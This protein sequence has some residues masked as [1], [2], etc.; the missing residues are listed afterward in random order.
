MKQYRGSK[1]I[2]AAPMTRA[3]YNAYRGWELPADE[4]GADEGYLV[5]YID[6]PNSN[7]EGHKGYISWSPKDVFERAYRLN[8]SLNFGDA[9]AAMKDGKRV[10][11]AGWNGEGMWIALSGTELRPS[12][13]E[14]KNLWSPHSQAEAEAQGGSVEV[15]PAIIMRT[16][17]GKIA[18]GWLASQ[19]DMLAEDW[20]ILD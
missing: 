18:M 7:H 19:A 9:I 4:D 1:T 16:A 5:E 17:D 14:T 15:L 20:S 13:V 11:R 8:G 10:C 6:S 12:R 3:E 2:L